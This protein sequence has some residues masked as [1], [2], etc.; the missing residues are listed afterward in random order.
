MRIAWVIVLSL[1][2]TGCTALPRSQEWT[3]DDFEEFV[4]FGGPTKSEIKN[5][6]GK[7]SLSS[8]SLD[9]ELWRYDLGIDFVTIQFR[10]DN[11]IHLRYHKDE[12]DIRGMGYRMRSIPAYNYPK[13]KQP[14]R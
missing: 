8:G 4:C 6:F 12:S 14:V 13:T 11:A 2:M 1:I 9:Y 7:P 3:V 5:H 10:N